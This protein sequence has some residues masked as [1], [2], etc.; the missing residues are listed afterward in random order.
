MPAKSRRHRQKLY[1]DRQTNNNSQTI[2]S[3]P[4][5]QSAITQTNKSQATYSTIPKLA[6][7]LD[8]SY[9]RHEIKWIGIVTGIVMI[10]LVICYIIWR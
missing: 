5:E 10:L 2:L 8:L 9:I 6:P 3:T 7:S 4:I 1:R